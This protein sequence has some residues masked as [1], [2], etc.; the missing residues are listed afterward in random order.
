[1]GGVTPARIACVIATQGRETLERAIRSVLSQD[2][3]PDDC[4]IIVVDTREMEPKGWHVLAEME[5]KLLAPSRDRISIRCTH[6]ENQRSTFSH[7]QARYGV[8]LVPEGHWISL[9]GDDDVYVPG[10]WRMIRAAAELGEPRP[11]LFRMDHQ[12]VGLIPEFG[13]VQEGRI[14][15]Q[16][17]IAPK[18]P[19]LVGNWDLTRYN[20][21][22]DWVRST[23]QRWDDRGIP[24]T[25]VEAT[26]QFCRPHER[27]YEGDR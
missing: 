7:E 11:L 3:R 17:L 10:A 18:L 22:F 19:G 14:S 12:T 6:H 23:L 25:W 24:P 1:M 2:L 20:G 4:L 5:A 8:S 16:C 15:E 26:I 21:D 9:L 27:G 13:T